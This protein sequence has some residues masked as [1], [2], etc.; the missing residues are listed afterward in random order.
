MAILFALFAHVA[1]GFRVAVEEQP[2]A[3]GG[4]ADAL[5]LKPQ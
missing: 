3:A 4:V 2:R 1:A 5:L